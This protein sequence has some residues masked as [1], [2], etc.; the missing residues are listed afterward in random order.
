MIHLNKQV[1][2]LIS[3]QLVY[4]Q[5]TVVLAFQL[6]EEGGGGAKKVINTGALQNVGAIFRIHVNARYTMGSVATRSGPVMV[7]ARFIE[8]IITGKGGESGY[9]TIPQHTIDPIFVTSNFVVSLQHLIVSRE[10]DP[11]D[12]QVLTVGKFQG[13]GALNI[14]PDS[15]SIGGTFRSF[16]KES[17]IQLKQRIDEIYL[18]KA[19]S[20]C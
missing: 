14:I 20:D 16:S 7:A 13:G 9:A 8:S 12:S 15:V 4:K 1:I 11:L 2:W 10:V 3:C 17:T 19:S 6:A 5:G 18:L